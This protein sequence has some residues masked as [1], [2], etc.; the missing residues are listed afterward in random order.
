MRTSR[1]A[2]GRGALILVWGLLAMLL[3]APAWAAPPRGVFVTRCTFSHSLRDDPIMFPGEAGA[4]HRH[5]F[6]GSSRTNATS[7]RRRMIAGP[8]TCSIAVDTAAYW[9]PSGFRG[10]TRL[11]PTL[12]KAYYFGLPEHSVLVPPPGS[13]LIGGNPSASSAEDNP[14]ATWSCGASGPH[15]TPIADHPYDC[16]PFAARWSFVDSVVAR[17]EFPNC[18][19][20]TGRGPEDVVYSVDHRCPAGFRNKVPAFR[21]QIHFGILDPCLPRSWCGPA[22]TGKDVVLRLSSGPYYTLHADFWNTWHQRA[23]SRLVHRCLDR[24]QHCGVVA[25][26]R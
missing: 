14:H 10:R 2:V 8:T 6:F 12:S 1:C 9:F 23:F 22:S 24:H 20:G 18:W 4:S 25:D 21:T 7:T 16:T 11:R 19:N 3:D 15:Q 26:R 17:I 13:K 5:E